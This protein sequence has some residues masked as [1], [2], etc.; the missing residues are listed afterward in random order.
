M[1]TSD[2]DFFLGGMQKQGLFFSTLGVNFQLVPQEQW[3]EGNPKW[4]LQAVFTHFRST[5]YIGK[6]TV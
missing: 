6:V 5:G 3:L 1:N 4:L 2:F